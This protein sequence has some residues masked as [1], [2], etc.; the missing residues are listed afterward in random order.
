MRTVLVSAGTIDPGDVT[1]WM[2][3]DSPEEAVAMVRERA[4]RDFGLTYA[5]R[6]RPRWW[7]GEKAPT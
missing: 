5:D 6:P 1:R 7:L 4:M 2:V 3:T